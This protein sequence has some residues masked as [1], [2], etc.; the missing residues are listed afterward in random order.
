[1]RKQLFTIACI[2]AMAATAMQVN[3][4]KKSDSVAG[5]TPLNF[6]VPPG[7]PA[8]KYD[9]TNNP[10][11]K[12]GFE[13]GRKLFY[14]G[15]LSKDGNFPC[16][17]CHQQFAAFAT[18]DHDL[19]HGFNNQFTT[20]NANGLFNLA[21]QKEFM[22]DGGI[23]NLEVQ[24]L[25]PIT[26][27]NE[28]AED[29]NNVVNKLKADNNYKRMFNAAFG[30]DEV[31]SQRMLKALAQFMVMLVS[32][33]SKYDRVKK[34]TA[35]FT[36]AEQSGY[37]IFKAKC[38]SCHTEPLFTDDS[39]RNNG[40]PVNSFFNDIGRMRITGRK[41]DSLK[42]KVPSLRNVDLTFYYMHDGRFYT[43]DQV[44]NHYASGIVNSPTLDP[45]LATPIVLTNAE[46]A[47]VKAFLRTLTDSTFIKDP[48]FN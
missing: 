48:K 4:C 38:A 6:E 1:M 41:E 25:A 11:T 47:N 31:N 30:S 33:D 27:P 15:I 10:V 22:W 14:D 8:P 42:F 3:S 2:V 23:N 34:G 20:R 21:W 26:A 36:A 35:S 9:F 46:R 44:L 12:E 16:A 28:M 37:T 43:L 7:F 32:A 17:S 40:L 18:F 24:P 19:S 45:L 39:Y 5:T 13:L 29:I